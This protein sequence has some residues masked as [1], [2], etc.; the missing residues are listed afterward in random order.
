MSMSEERLEMGKSL[1]AE[2]ERLIKELDKDT[3]DFMELIMY[4][5]HIKSKMTLQFFINN[6]DP[7]ILNQIAKMNE[8]INYVADLR[9][10]QIA[11]S[12]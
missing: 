4:M 12:M 7:R 3:H 2:L 9:E 5:E 10:R 11:S 1:L 6:E 8:I